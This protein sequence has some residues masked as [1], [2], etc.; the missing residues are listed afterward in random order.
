MNNGWK[1]LI[2]CKENRIALMTHG[3]VIRDLLV[4]YAPKGK[5]FLIG[6]FPMAGDMSWYGK[7]GTA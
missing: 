5:S 3:G 2:A 7:T 6:E 4:R 1:Q